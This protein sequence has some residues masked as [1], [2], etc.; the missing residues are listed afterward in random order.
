MIRLVN[1]TIGAH[2][3]SLITRATERISAVE[4]DLSADTGEVSR[5]VIAIFCNHSNQ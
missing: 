3:V 5:V 1:E 2:L 4:G